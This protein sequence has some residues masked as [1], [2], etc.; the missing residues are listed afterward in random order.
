MKPP[1]HNQVVADIKSRKRS[2]GQ[3]LDTNAHERH[4]QPRIGIG[5]LKI[6]ERAKALVL[7]AL[8]TTASPTGR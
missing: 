8:T 3:R 4:G 2:S 7:E 1:G 5:T 6:T